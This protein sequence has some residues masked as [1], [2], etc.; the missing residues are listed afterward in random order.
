MKQHELTWEIKITSRQ[1]HNHFY[2]ELSW[3]EFIFV[4]TVLAVT[5]VKPKTKFPELN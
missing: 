2:L 4:I 3:N 1:H 5:I